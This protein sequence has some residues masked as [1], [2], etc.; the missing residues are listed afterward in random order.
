MGD[1]TEDYRRL[2][3][4]LLAAGV[5]H[6]APDGETKTRKRHI[7]PGPE[8]G[9]GRKIS[10]RLGIE[11]HEPNC[12]KKIGSLKEALFVCTKGKKG[13]G[14]EGVNVQSNP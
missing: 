1:K 4:G 9:K 6:G 10:W 3:R 2:K 14:G 8:K 7:S 11:K 13:G 12:R 5:L